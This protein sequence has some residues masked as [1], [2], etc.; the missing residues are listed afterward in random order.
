MSIFQRWEECSL[1][2]MGGKITFIPPNS[3]AEVNDGNYSDYQN[4]KAELVN[5]GWEIVKELDTPPDSFNPNLLGFEET[6]LKRK[7]K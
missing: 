5:G 2:F 3:W 7:K 4:R 1:S 6:K